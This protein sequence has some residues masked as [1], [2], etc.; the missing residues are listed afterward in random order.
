MSL[1]SPV[2]VAILALLVVISVAASVWIWPRLANTRVVTVLGRLG[3]LIVVNVCVL[4]LSFALLN[5]QFQ[6]F[7]DWTDL[8]GTA[9]TQVTSSQAGGAASLAAQVPVASPTSAVATATATT[10]SSA[11]NGTVYSVTGGQSGVTSN[12]LVYLPKGYADPANATRRYPVLI[13]FGGYPST[14]Y[15]LANGFRISGTLE[16]LT[17]R[18]AL[19]PVIAV[20]VQPWTPAGRDTEC[21]NGGGGAGDQVETWAAVDVPAW[22]TVHF[23]AVTARS[24]WATWGM[25][26]GGWCAAMTAML[27]PDRFAA[28]ISLGGYFR[29]SWGNWQPFHAGDPRLHRY[30]LVALA[31]SSP[32]PVA[33]WVFTSKPDGLGYP[34]TT[35]LMAAAHPPLSVTAQVAASG[36][37]RFST[38]QPWLP[39]ALT[40]LGRNVSGFAPKP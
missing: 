33:L 12:V 37:H 30:D 17:G 9:S 4:L 35:A 22:L 19:G 28:A 39:V 2:L 13:G 20:F 25:S 7:S 31:G 3:L 8:M 21:V 6:F 26:A 14:V 32:P 36:G 11:G 15:Q 10:V 5:D 29:P 18:G 34:S 24:G 23:R 16:A 40:W 38:W 1:T 27:H